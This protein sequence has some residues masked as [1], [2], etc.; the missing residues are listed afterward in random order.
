M[1]TA[2]LTAALMNPLLSK[3]DQ[4]QLM[5]AAAALTAQQHGAANFLIP[6]EIKSDN[7]ND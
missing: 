6:S 1:S 7:N 5:A 3:Q 4:A 2:A